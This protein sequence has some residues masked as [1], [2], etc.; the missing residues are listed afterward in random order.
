M[1][2][3]DRRFR[4]FFLLFV[5]LVF[6]IVH[7]NAEALTLSP[8]RIEV[9]GDPGTTITKDITLLNDS[10]AGT[11]TYYVTYANFEAQGETGSPF[12]APPKDDLGTWMTTT[13]SVT[14]APNETKTITL[15][16]NIPKDAYAGGHFAVVFFGNTPQ[17]GQISVGAK[18]G[19]LVLLSVNGNV[20]EAG[21]LVSFNTLKHQF[22]YNSLPVSLEYRFKN[23][24]NDRVKPTGNVTMHD[25]FYLPVATIDANPVTGNILPHSTRLFNLDWVKQGVDPNA[26][27]PSSFF[28]FFFN[29]VAYQWENFAVGL[30]FA[31]LNLVYGTQ[32]IH[33]SQTAMFFVFPW[34]LLLC[35]LIVL[36]II[37]FVG[38]ILLRR[39]NRYI[40][41]KARATPN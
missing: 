38:R 28:G 29:R 18:T 41:E 37:L 20:L 23:D 6:F 17:G 26:V 15:N 12:F 11:E 3:G 31:K 32:N 10:S 4:L 19:T 5:F 24:G 35:M 25:L 2:I 9:S 21:G 13:S 27:P 8:A 22:F 1:K 16:I 14:L 30:Y 34:Q 36:L 40:I 7:N 39:Y 33:S